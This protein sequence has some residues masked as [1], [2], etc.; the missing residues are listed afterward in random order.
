LT[1]GH[2]REVTWIPFAGYFL[3]KSTTA[4]EDILYKVLRYAVFGGVVALAA[5]LAPVRGSFH[6]RAW[7]TAGWGMA[8]STAIEVCQI[9]IP[10]RYVDL[11]HV[12][13]AGWGSYTGAIAA[14][15]A[16]DYYHTVRRLMLAGPAGKPLSAMARQA[17]PEPTWNVE[18]PAAGQDAP[19]EKTPTS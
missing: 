15:W 12:L 18:I 7:R 10:T 19:K 9:A 5:G 4:A 2:W 13:L 8:L 11:T 14:R 6:R 17:S 3:P 16:A 1:H